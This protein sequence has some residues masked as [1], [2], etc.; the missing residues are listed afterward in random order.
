M[1][2]LIYLGNDCGI[3]TRWFTR[4]SLLHGW[5]G[6]W[7]TPGSLTASWTRVSR[8]GV[9][10]WGGISNLS[11]AFARPTR[12][13][14][15]RPCWLGRNTISPLLRS[16]SWD[17]LKLWLTLFLVLVC[18]NFS[19]FLPFLVVLADKMLG[20]IEKSSKMRNAWDY[21][22]A[23]SN[24]IRANGFSASPYSWCL[25]RYESC[26]VVEE[27]NCCQACFLIGRAC[28]SARVP[29]ASCELFLSCLYFCCWLV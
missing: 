19:L 20:C 26:F 14:I 9:A 27:I 18:L 3:Y 16:S 25:D 29:M 6:S 17:L 22:V 28:D 24:F 8:V 4:G 15:L 2:Y 11:V 1:S 12:P 5:T 10:L 23:T 13:V 7:F 21:R